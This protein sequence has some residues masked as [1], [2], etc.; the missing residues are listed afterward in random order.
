MSVL[1][2]SYKGLD[3][4]VI[5]GNSTDG[6]REVIEKYASGISKYVSE[7]DNGIYDAMN[8][9]IDLISGDY[10]CFMNSGDSFVNDQVL[11]DIFGQS[12]QTTD[13]VYGS[14][15]VVNGT[16][17]R[18]YPP[19]ALESI[20][21]GRL[22]F[23]HQSVFLKSELF[24]KYGFNDTYRVNADYDLFLGLFNR[25]S[26]FKEVDTVVSYYALGGVS[27]QAPKADKEK[28]QIV[29]SYGY[30][31]IPVQKLIIEKKLKAFVK[32]ILSIEKKS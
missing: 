30:S 10:V 15:I 27:A 28:L 32:R 31:T 18:R 21:N 11:Q 16:K 6:T 1:N 9:S 13:V 25:K 14:T 5:D 12:E 2:Q 17:K 26:T 3:Y 29:A 22:P 23:I 24:R 8:K 4:V 19:R 20:K 7:P